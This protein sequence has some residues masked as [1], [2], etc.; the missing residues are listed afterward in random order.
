MSNEIRA[1]GFD[2]QSFLAPRKTSSTTNESLAR[3][4]KK[5]FTRL[6]STATLIRERVH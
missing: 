2:Y 3:G 4:A 1:G 5:Q 6:T